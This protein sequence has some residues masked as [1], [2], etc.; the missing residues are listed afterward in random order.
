ML[1]D[2]FQL[3]SGRQVSIERLWIE[4]TYGGILVGHP[5]YVSTFLRERTAGELKQKHGLDVAVLFPEKHLLPSYRFTA[6]LHSDPLPDTMQWRLDS[7]RKDL[8]LGYHWDLSF[9]FVCWFEKSLNGNLVELIKSATR[10]VEWEK[11]AKNSS[12]D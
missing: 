1:T 5:D 7:I 8:P 11:Y 12:C 10:S 3:D 9:M 2:C 4:N 6:S